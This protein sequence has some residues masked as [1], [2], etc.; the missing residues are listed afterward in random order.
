MYVCMLYITFI[1]SFFIKISLLYKYSKT[2]L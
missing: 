1:L 2:L